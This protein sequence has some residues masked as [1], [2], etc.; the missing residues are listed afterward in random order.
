MQIDN[1]KLLYSN[2]YLSAIFDESLVIQAIHSKVEYDYLW[3]SKNA[4]EMAFLYNNLKDDPII[5]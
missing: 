3:S 5:K 2:N 1:G 4:I